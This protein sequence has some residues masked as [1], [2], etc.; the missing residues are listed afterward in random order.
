MAPR[1][2]PLK[3]ENDRTFREPEQEGGKPGLAYHLYSKRITFTLA[4]FRQ[5]AQNLSTRQFHRDNYE[6]ERPDDYVPTEAERRLYGMNGNLHIEK[7]RVIGFISEEGIEIDRNQPFYLS[8]HT[9]GADAENGS[10]W[11]FEEGEYNDRE[12]IY[13]SVYVSEER[14]RW[15]WEQMRLRPTAKVALTLEVKLWQHAVDNMAA[16]HHHFQ[17]FFIEKSAERSSSEVLGCTFFLADEET[18]PWKDPYEVEDD[19]EDEGAVPAPQA[20]GKVAKR[21]VPEVEK[22]LRRLI[23]GVG[24]VIGLLSVI[25]FLIL[26]TSGS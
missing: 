8:M 12:G 23:R 24:W 14:M 15:L 20:K 1:R 25:L 4:E 26:A 6:R 13:V 7:N 3:R 18:P 17:E 9:R 21:D 10:I 11:F 22:L 19:W 16:E 2:G 5:I